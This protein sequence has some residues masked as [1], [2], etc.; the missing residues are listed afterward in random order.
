MDITQQARHRKEVCSL[1]FWHP[2]QNQFFCAEVGVLL[3]AD[4]QVK[5]K[6]LQEQTQGW[7][8]R[9]LEEL[10]TRPAEEDLL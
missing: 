8:K 10:K 3:K 7:V 1:P 6:Q 2:V 9:F 5:M 4:D